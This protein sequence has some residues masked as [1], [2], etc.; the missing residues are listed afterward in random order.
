MQLAFPDFLTIVM[1]LGGLA[2]AVG[3][4]VFIRDF[5]RMQ[6]G[7]RAS[8]FSA[9]AAST[10]SRPHTLRVQAFMPEGLLWHLTRL[11]GLQVVSTRTISGEPTR[12]ESYFLYK[13][14]LFIMEEPFAVTISL[15]GQPPDRALFAEIEAHVQ[16]YNRLTS[17]PGIIS[18]AFRFLW[19]PR[20]PPRRVLDRYYPD[21]AAAP[22]A[23]RDS[24][25]LSRQGNDGG[26]DPLAEAE[27]Y[28]AG[29][30]KEMAIQL[31]EQALAGDPTPDR[32]RKRLS[33]LKCGS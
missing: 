5:G 2:L 14:R 33:E 28:V 27:V 4:V 18:G 12:F 10:P 1:V 29:G 9:H 15:L 26:I 32:I 25:H 24:V 6:S 7:L 11:P 13:E 8:L 21:H 30:H 16:R 19:L 17:L 20:H 22:A 23:E 3:L 31:L